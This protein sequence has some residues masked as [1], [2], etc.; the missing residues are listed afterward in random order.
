VLIARRRRRGKRNR[1][2]V[3][4]THDSRFDTAALRKVNVPVMYDTS[5]IRKGLKG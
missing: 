1:R 4:R 3:E 5:D 2:A